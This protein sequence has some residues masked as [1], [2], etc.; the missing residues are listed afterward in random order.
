ML[1]IVLPSLDIDTTPVVTKEDAE[2]TA[3]KETTRILLEN[4]KHE[5]IYISELPEH[6]TLSV[7]SIKLVIHNPDLIQVSISNT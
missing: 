2:A 5:E 3:I 6:Y 1:G 7:N 4:F